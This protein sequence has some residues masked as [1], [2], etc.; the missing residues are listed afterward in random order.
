VVEVKF[1]IVPW[2]ILVVLVEIEIVAVIE[3]E[4]ETAT[5]VG[6]LL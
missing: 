2:Q 4:T 5:Q 6:T 1:V 3:G